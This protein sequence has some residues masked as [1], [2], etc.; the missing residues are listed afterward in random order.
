MSTKYNIQ[1]NVLDVVL[2][3]EYK[4]SPVNVA[5]ARILSKHL[6]RHR[7][8]ARLIGTSERTIRRWLHGNIQKTPIRGR[9]RL[10]SEDAD[11]KLENLVKL[12]TDNGD[13]V[14]IE[15]LRDAAGMF[16]YRLFK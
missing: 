14:T 8:I 11:C 15:G 6:V 9:P 7:E 10:L 5:R 13:S 2:S 16:G 4:K 12:S 1:P 3:S